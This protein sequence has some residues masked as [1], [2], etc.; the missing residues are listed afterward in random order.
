MVY[1]IFSHLSDL[2]VSVT[3]E[4]S[5]YGIGLRS[6]YWLPGCSG[7]YMGCD[8]LSFACGIAGY[9]VLSPC[10]ECVS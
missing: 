8:V 2:V 10:C 5:R 3:V 9:D 1:A 4:V 6:E 7:V